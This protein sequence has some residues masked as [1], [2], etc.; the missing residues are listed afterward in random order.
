MVEVSV[1]G[2]VSVVVSKW[3]KSKLASASVRAV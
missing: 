3:L 2:Y 1:D